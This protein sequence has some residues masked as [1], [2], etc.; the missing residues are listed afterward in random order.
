[1]RGSDDAIRSIER[2]LRRS[3]DA[4]RAIRVAA[5]G[6]ELRD[7]WEDFLGHTFS[8]FDKMIAQAIGNAASKAWG[9][10]LKNAWERDDPG[11]VYIKEARNSETHGFVPYGNFTNPAVVIPRLLSIGTAKSVSFQGFTINGEPTNDFNMEVKNGRVTRLEGQP[12]LPIF[13]V[14]ASVRLV[15]IYSNTKNRKFPVPSSLMGRAVDPGQP[16][17]LASAASD[18]ARDSLNALRDLI[19]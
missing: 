7:A 6:E 11:L 3:N 15:D 17:S 19:E 9:H 16:L 8:A 12:S 18:H 14:P 4:L 10:R 5:T 2:H 13:E 1:M